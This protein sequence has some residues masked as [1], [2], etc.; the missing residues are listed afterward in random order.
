[1]KSKSVHV[2]VGVVRDSRQR[3]LVAQRQ[4]G[5]HLAGL[6]EFPGGKVENGEEV[7]HALARELKEEVGITIVESEPLIEIQ[8]EYPEKTVLLDVYCVKNFI[9]EAVGREGQTIQWVQQRDLRTIN[10][11]DV[12]R[13]IINALD[14]P[15][16]VGITGSFDS[17]TQFK[18]S[19]ENLI[20]AGVRLIQLRPADMRQ[21]IPL[22]LIRYACEE[23]ARAGVDLQINSCLFP[24]IQHI[25]PTYTH[26]GL[27]LRSSDLRQAQEMRE[28]F[29]FK[30]VSAACHSIDEVE[31]ANN[32]QLDFIL[33]SPVKETQ[34][35]LDA[36]PIGWS[37]FA[38]LCKKAKMPVYALGGLK[39]SDIQ[40]AREVGGQ[41]IASI[42]A[43]WS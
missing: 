15:D 10:F 25:D 1:M 41:G 28:E 36:I 18:S 29:N 6:W 43:F 19:F 5:Q 20:R 38:E 24:S 40:T 22:G 31:F 23:S 9:G 7:I 16:T 30:Y 11:P 33:L 37:C 21:E 32:L 17:E 13:V 14:L 26:I 12:N 35:H 2:A 42:S 39:P 34:T 8:H 3:I 27:H 4:T